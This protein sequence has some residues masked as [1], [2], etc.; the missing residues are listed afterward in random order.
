MFAS[1]DVGFDHYTGDGAFSDTKLLADSV[2]YLG[3][4]VVILL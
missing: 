3:L 1:I 2:D 4:I